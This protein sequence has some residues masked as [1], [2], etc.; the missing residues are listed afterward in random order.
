MTTPYTARLHDLSRTS[1]T[2][3]AD[4]QEDQPLVTAC[5]PS[6]NHRNYVRES[7]QSIIDQDYRHIELVVIDDGSGFTA[8]TR[9]GVRVV[10]WLSI[11]EPQ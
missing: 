5:I 2:A 10:D 9:F 6:Y 8:W 4:C 3:S 11:P 7:V 1:L